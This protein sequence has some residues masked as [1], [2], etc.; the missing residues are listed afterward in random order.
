MD[1]HLCCLEE[2]FCQVFIKVP[3]GEL[4]PTDAALGVFQPHI[5]ENR[6]IDV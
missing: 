2:E 6:L 3:L 1:G 4:R 5:P